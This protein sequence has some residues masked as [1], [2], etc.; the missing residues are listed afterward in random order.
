MNKKREKLKDNIVV[1]DFIN[2]VK[3]GGGLH[4][5]QHNMSCSPH[6]PSGRANE[7]SEKRQQQQQ[8]Q[9]EKKHRKHPQ[10][11]FFG[12]IDFRPTQPLTVSPSRSTALT[13]PP[14]NIKYFKTPLRPFIAA[15]NMGYVQ[16][17]K[18]G[19]Q[20]EKKAT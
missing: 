15:E 8:Q 14:R 11:L 17:K 3:E 2:K 18:S 12:L 1:S 7:I 19:Q 4:R 13:S 10:F 20:R 5:I 6:D 9:R 16:Q